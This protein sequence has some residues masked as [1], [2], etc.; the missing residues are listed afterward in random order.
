MRQ[1]ALGVALFVTFCLSLGVAHGQATGTGDGSRTGDGTTPF[2]GL[3]QA[4][5]ADLFLGS[6]TTRIPIQVPPNRGSLTPQLALVYNSSAGPSPYGHGWDLSLPRLQRTAKHGVLNCSDTAV[7]N[8]FVLT[9]PGTSIECTVNSSGRCEPHVESGFIRIQ[10]VDGNATEF[11]AT[12]KSGIVYTFGGD[13][14]VTTTWSGGFS[15]AAGQKAVTGSST[16]IG[17]DTN[18]SPCRYISA[19]ALR[20]VEDPNGNTIEYQYVRDGEMLYPHSIVYGGNVQ[21]PSHLFTVQ[22]L[23][24][25]RSDAPIAAPSTAVEDTVLN[26]RG[27]HL[28]TMSYRLWRINV[29]TAP[30][31]SAAT[32]RT[33]TRLGSAGRRSSNR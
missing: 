29:L 24:Q 16:S 8:E 22:F 3:A 23:W 7:R 9:L 19:W 4:P 32:R 21:G 30:N 5:E 26:A 20:K 12:D 11:T 2:T 18:A 14:A 6:A 33:T 15:P 17:F 31:W 10:R 1:F 27:G 25:T 13:G 28:A